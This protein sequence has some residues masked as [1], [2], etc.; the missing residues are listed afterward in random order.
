MVA[1]VYPDTPSPSLYKTKVL[2]D[3]ST[4]ADGLSD[5]ID[6]GGLAMA[7]YCLSTNWT[8]TS[9]TF[10]GSHLSTDEMRNI[11]TSTGA[12]L[13]HQVGTNRLIAANAPAEMGGVRYL[14]FRSGTSAVPV[15]QTT[16][17]EQIC[18]GLRQIT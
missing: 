10:R 15:A 3:V 9:I 5:I 11:Y 4:A 17:G 13:V 7:S 14:Q 12:E 16:T 18:V 1:T 8:S 6:M 2:I